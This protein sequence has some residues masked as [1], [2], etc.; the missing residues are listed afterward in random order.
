MRPFKLMLTVLKLTLQS[1]S[2]PSNQHHSL[3]KP[4]ILTQLT[5]SKKFQKIVE[6]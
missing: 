6:T 1:F 4:K 2:T 5:G 3:F